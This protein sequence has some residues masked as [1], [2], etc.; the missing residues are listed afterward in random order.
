MFA[1]YLSVDMQL[2]LMM[3]NLL[4]VYTMTIPEGD[5]GEIGTQFE[6]GTSVLRNPKPYRVIFKLKD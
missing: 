5:E 4:T 2:F 3:S 6:A 1:R